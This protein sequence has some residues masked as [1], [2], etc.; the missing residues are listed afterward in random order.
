M[1]ITYKLRTYCWIMCGRYSKT[2]PWIPED[3]FSHPTA[4]EPFVDIFSQNRSRFLAEIFQKHQRSRYQIRITWARAKKFVVFA[5]PIDLVRSAFTV[6]AVRLRR[7]EQSLRGIGG[8]LIA[9]KMASPVTPK[10]N[11]IAGL[12]LRRSVGS[13]FCGA[14]PARH[15]VSDFSFVQRVFRYSYAH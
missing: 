3:Q 6:E 13:K 14:L 4:E 2:D 8:D 5:V 7:L 9:A 1:K 10:G 11:R 15:H 12:R